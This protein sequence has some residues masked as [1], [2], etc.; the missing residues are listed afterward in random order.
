MK[1]LTRIRARAAEAEKHAAQAEA[2]RK[3]ITANWPYIIA[4]AER[5]RQHRRENHFT[6]LVQQVA[7]GT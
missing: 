1:F 2:E 4:Q 6:E 5:S 3:R 7:R